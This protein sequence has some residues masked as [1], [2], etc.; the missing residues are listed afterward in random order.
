MWY[1]LLI[2]LIMI[3]VLVLSPCNQK[4]S[5]EEIMFTCTCVLGQRFVA[6]TN[7]FSLQFC[8]FIKH[9][10]A[11]NSI[12]TAWEQFY[13]HFHPFCAFLDDCDRTLTNLNPNVTDVQLIQGALDQTN[14][15]K[16]MLTAVF[17]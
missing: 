12:I 8:R 6:D 3:S 17:V 1:V 7:M 16:I 4:V 15:R 13:K 5:Y 2:E 11:L 10:S 14:V 9:K